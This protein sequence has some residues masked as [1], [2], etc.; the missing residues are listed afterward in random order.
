[1]SVVPWQGAGVWPLHSFSIRE[2]VPSDRA[3]GGL[4]TGPS[5]YVCGGG[6][7]RG[8][9]D[10]QTRRCK[11]L[12]RNPGMG[13]ALQV[14]VTKG[15]QPHCGMSLASHCRKHNPLAACNVAVPCHVCHKH[16][17]LLC[18]R[19][20]ALSQPHAGEEKTD[21][22]PSVCPRSTHNSLALTQVCRMAQ[23]KPPPAHSA[24]TTWVAARRQVHPVQHM[25]SC[26]SLMQQPA[27]SQGHTQTY[28]P[29]R[30]DQLPHKP[31]SR[32]LRACWAY[33][34]RLAQH[35][36]YRTRQNP[37][38]TT[39]SARHHTPSAAAAASTAP[40][41]ASSSSSKPNQT[42]PRSSSSSQS[43]VKA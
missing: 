22:L 43:T 18:A 20:T 1:M 21:L 29:A 33:A 38:A 39:A 42:A 12:Y 23:N 15:S 3:F 13:C 27:Q 2:L 17:V 28:P 11:V 35:R 14:V 9:S 16:K 6:G 7:L 31:L 37:A 36:Q 30:T 24:A 32:A 26:S 41:T 10:A 34:A 19:L 5:F 25:L 4:E 40:A 8:G